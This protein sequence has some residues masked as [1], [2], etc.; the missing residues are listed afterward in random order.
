MCAGLHAA[1][2]FHELL[3]ALQTRRELRVVWVDADVE[4]A[5]W[6]LLEHYSQLVLSLTDATSAVIARQQRVAEVF[7]F[8]SD[9]R[10]LGFTLRPS[11]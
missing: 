6:G 2:A 4:A 11:T 3:A 5:G 10:A 1:M 8:D 9:F 7:G